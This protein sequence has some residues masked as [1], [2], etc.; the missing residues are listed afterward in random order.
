MTT[1]YNSNKKSF[2]E[3]ISEATTGEKITMLRARKRWSQNQLAA[4]TG[5]S[6][7]A[8]YA[9]EHGKRI[10]EPRSIRDLANA[11]GV[12]DEDLA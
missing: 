2:L 3:I 9:W 11:L 10:P 12:R 6:A 8:I 5:L 7:D 1:Y 4:K